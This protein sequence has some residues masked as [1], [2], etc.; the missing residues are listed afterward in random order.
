MPNKPLVDSE[1]ESKV[2]LP[3]ESL[4]NFGENKLKISRR[5]SINPIIASNFYSRR[6]SKR[7]SISGI[8]CSVMFNLN[9]ICDTSEL[10]Q[11]YGKSIY[12]VSVNN[13]KDYPPVC[14]LRNYDVAP[15]TLKT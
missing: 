6:A 1:P 15:K 14:N 12:S 9:K 2:T 5:Q 8:N 13:N 3:I 7:G 11:N 10:N 4:E